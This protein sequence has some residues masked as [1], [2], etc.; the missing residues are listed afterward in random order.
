M[1]TIDP[2]VEALAI[3]YYE[4]ATMIG[5]SF[6]LKVPQLAGVLS[7][8]AQETPNAETRMVL[9]AISHQLIHPKP[10]I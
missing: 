9:E 6:D 3:A 8:R 1:P 5:R 4:L 7:R 10:T 2:Q